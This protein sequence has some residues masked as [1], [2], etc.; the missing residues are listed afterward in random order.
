MGWNHSYLEKREDLAHPA[1]DASGFF[2][3]L[4]APRFY[5]PVFGQ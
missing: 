2:A 3:M 1:L 5:S 4:Q